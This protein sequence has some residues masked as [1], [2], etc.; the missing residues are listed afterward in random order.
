MKKFL[1]FV[2]L[3]GCF[4][5]EETI[6]IKDFDNYDL[7]YTIYVPSF[8]T[9]IVPEDS[10]IRNINDDKVKWKKV[11]TDTIKGISKIE[12][13]YENLN[14]NELIQKDS[15]MK[16]FKSKDYIEFYKFLILSDTLTKNLL[17]FITDENYYK[18]TIF[19]KKEILQSN[20]DSISKEKIIWKIPLKKLYEMKK[21]D[22]I[23]IVFRI[24]V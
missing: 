21:D 4:S 23:K 10:I 18:I 22:T 24:K 11:E 12:V 14:L 8:I 9:Q 3:F 13:F 20:A 2:F 17:P 7:L 6:W 5:I 1:V 16:F 15:T 19:S